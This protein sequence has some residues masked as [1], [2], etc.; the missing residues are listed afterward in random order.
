LILPMI[1]SNYHNSSSFF[2]KTRIVLVFLGI[3]PFLLVVSLFIYE[4]IQ[5]TD[6]VILFSALA[7]L[8]ILTGFTLLRRSADHL[9]ALSRET[10]IIE[11]GE[12]SEPIQIKADQELNDIAD[13]F[14][15]IHKRLQEVN[16][17]IREQ[18]VQLMIYG[19][20]ISLSYKKMKEEEELRYRLSRYVGDNLLEKLINAKDGVFLENER[21]EVTILFADIRSFT[22]I[23]EIMEAEE[24]VSM[25]NQFF[26]I[27]VDIIFRNNGILDKFI[28]DELMAVFGL[29]ASE[30]TSSH[31]AIQAA[32]EMQYATE[33]LMK[34]RAKEAKETFEIGIGV[35]TGS[36]IVGNVGSEN[37]MDYTVIGNSVNVAARLEQI[38]KGGEIFIGEQTY[39]Q[40]QTHFPMLKKGK[41]SMK[42]KTEP[43]TCYKVLR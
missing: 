37:R 42:N 17:E 9:V 20:D 25:L 11:A 10:G 3:T 43:V 35:N 27:M 12:K 34:A 31:D 38:A 28:G 21:K 7:L 13:H 40:T 33:D 6:M 36:T 8:S 22:T 24:L 1:K 19:R 32:I 39:R 14:N 18:S 16:R 26:G 23:A 5:L 15:S 4:K 2:A 29:I 41:L 30:N